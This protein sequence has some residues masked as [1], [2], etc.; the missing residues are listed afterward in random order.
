MFSGVSEALWTVYCAYDDTKIHGKMQ[1]CSTLMCLCVAELGRNRDG[2]ANKL[3][4]IL[5]RGIVADSIEHRIRVRPN[6]LCSQSLWGGASFSV[7]VTRPDSYKRRL[8]GAEEGG[9]LKVGAVAWLCLGSS[10]ARAVVEEELVFKGT[11]QPAARRWPAADRQDSGLA[12]EDGFWGTTL[13]FASLHVLHRS[14][15]TP[16]T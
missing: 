7:V 10:L 5:G 14:V 15:Q 2:F 8:A 1:S 12:V 6:R 3:D 11:A 16:V 9:G 4:K 13:P